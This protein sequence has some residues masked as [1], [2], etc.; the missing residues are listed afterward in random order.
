MTPASRRLIARAP[1][2]PLFS[3]SLSLSLFLNFHVRASFSS[4]YS[5]QRDASGA[6]FV[7]RILGVI[8]RF[9]LQRAEHSFRETCRCSLP[10][11]KGRKHREQPPLV[12]HLSTLFP[13]FAKASSFHR[14]SSTDPIARILHRRFDVLNSNPKSP[15]ETFSRWCTSLPRSMPRIVKRTMDRWAHVT[16]EPDKREPNQN[17]TVR[18][19]L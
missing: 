18:K 7:L 2:E 10:R 13:S 4:W 17:F 9:L 19:R 14:L 5:W 6:P 1:N 8:Y 3:G 12:A 15:G 11:G 16:R